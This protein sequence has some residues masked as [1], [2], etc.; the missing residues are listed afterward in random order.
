MRIIYVLTALCIALCPLT[1]Q[2]QAPE[3]NWPTWR[4]PL[5]NGF[6]P[7]G[8]PPITWS[9]TENVKW[10]VPLPG[11]GSST[12]IIWG[13]KIFIQTATPT[14]GD[15]DPA[16]KK[17]AS[18]TA[19]HEKVPY[20]FS[21]ICINRQNGKTLWQKG[22]REEIPHQGHHPTSNYAS[23]SPVTD[24]KLLWVSFGSRGL[25]CFDFEGNLKWSQNLVQLEI[26]Y[27]FGES[28]SPT[29]AGDAVIVLQDHE[30]QSKI[31]AYHKLTGKLL[32]DVDREEG[33]TWSSPLAVQVG[34]TMQVIT[35]ATNYIRAYDALNGDVI[36]QCSG[37]SVG[38][39]PTPISGF[40]NVYCAS[41][42]KGDA[43][44][45]INLNSKGDVSNSEAVV[46]SI[47]KHTPY[48]PSPTLYEGNLYYISGMKGLFNCV[49]AKTGEAFYLNER[50]TGIKQVY[51][52]PMGVAGRLYVF[53]RDGKAMVIK[54][55][56]TFEVLAENELN[57]GFDASPAVVGD[58]LYLRGEKHLYCIAKS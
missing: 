25:H 56:R 45:A 52:S 30:G 27:S 9:E 41:S 17:S 48:V 6:S 40:G 10:K 20:T 21:V 16:L 34:D 4:G 15:I 2:A 18:N 38:A 35:C 28:S 31:T 36:W 57:E 12:P 13:D 39:I 7:K 19:V 46:W 50:L 22:V 26:R 29:L 32:W 54:H 49:D 51:A 37:L 24:G 55:S 44:M 11:S 5:E 58:E 47:T 8:N 33:T 14:E 43:L 1:A 3:D 42:F 23:F 53:G